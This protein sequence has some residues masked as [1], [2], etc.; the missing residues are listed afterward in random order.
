MCLCEWMKCPVRSKWGALLC[1]ST[2]I[3]YGLWQKPV[4]GLYQPA[5]ARRRRQWQPTLVLLPRKSH[6]WRSLVG[7]SPWGHEESD[8]TEWLH[9]HFSL[10]C[11][12]EGNGSPLQCSCL[13]NPRDR[14][15][16]WAWWVYGVTQSQTWLKWLSS[17]SCCEGMAQGPPKGNEFCPRKHLR[18]WITESLYTLNKQIIVN[19]QYL[20]LKKRYSLI[21]NC[22][23]FCKV[24][25]SIVGF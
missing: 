16:W 19:Q 7:Y 9:F 1:G 8:T 10:S 15:A 2:V 13:E 4:G 12:G 17:P 22:S 25:P 5:N 18:G 11:I 14:G 21:K 24:F 3:S 6:G 23:K 20:N